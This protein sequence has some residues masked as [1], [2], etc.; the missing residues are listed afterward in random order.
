M[1]WLFIPAL[2]VGFV[3]WSAIHEARY[4]KQAIIVLDEAGKFECWLPTD[5][6]AGPG[7]ALYDLTDKSQLEDLMDL[8]DN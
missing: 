5:T 8:L 2:L 6:P 1:E 3:A 7:H 4:R